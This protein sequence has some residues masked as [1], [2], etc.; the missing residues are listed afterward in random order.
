MHLHHVNDQNHHRL[1]ILPT[2]NLCRYFRTI[3]CE[4]PEAGLSANR[5]VPFEANSNE[6]SIISSLNGLTL[7][8]YISHGI[9]YELYYSCCDDDYRLLCLTLH[10]DAY[11]YSLNSD[12]WRKVELPSCPPLQHLMSSCL[13]NENLYFLE[14]SRKAPH[15]WSYLI[16]RFNTSTEKFTK[17]AAPSLRD[18]TK[19]CF[20]LT[21]VSG[22]VYLCASSKEHSWD[23]LELWKMDRDGEWTKVTTKEV[24][25]YTPTLTDDPMK[26][27]WGGKFVE[28][29][30]SLS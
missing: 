30:V 22:C 7:S 26:I 20:S 11:I 27:L 28:T 23:E 5:S 18:V 21:V 6:M 8:K 29:I 12:S 25:R 3:D 24:W 10:S 4:T 1:L 16:L 17:I 15:L 14:Q 13:L 9:R 2:T 19:Y